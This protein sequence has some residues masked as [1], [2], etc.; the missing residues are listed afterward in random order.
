M[1][2]IPDMDLELVSF[3]LCPYVQRAVIALKEK[4]VPYDIT[5]IDLMDPP[6]W[7]REISPLGKVPLLKVGDEVLFESAVISEYI[8]ETSAG[9]LHPEDAL[10][11]AKHR[12]WIEFAS[13]CLETLYTLNTTDDEAAFEE[14][15]Q[16]MADRLTKVE[17]ILGSGPFF[18][19]TAFSLVDAAFAPL[20]M[21]LDLLQQLAGVEVMAQLP[22]I[23]AWRD[24]LLQRESIQQSV[25]EEFPVIYKGML[26]M[27][28]G[29]AGS[30][31]ND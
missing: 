25:V 14:A 12:G 3:K 7:F 1:E 2:R 9:S 24:Q 11:R 16:T 23:S 15:V 19:G 20:L 17:A 22:K 10:Q 31:V 26:K 13:S 27:K 21:R 4:Q 28:A 8:D 5:Y 6:D 30:R 18:G 29:V